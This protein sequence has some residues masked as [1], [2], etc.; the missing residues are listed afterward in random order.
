MWF[1]H[2]NKLDR[3][4]ENFNWPLLLATFTIDTF[5]FIAI[6]WNFNRSSAEINDDSIDNDD[7]NDD[8]YNYGDELR[9]ITWNEKSGDDS[10]TTFIKWKSIEIQSNSDVIE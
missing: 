4:I 3:S 1:V 8:Q 6:D 10:S 2:L 9:P 7:D 5:V